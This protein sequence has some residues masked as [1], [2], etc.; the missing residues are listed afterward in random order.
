MHIVF[1]ALLGLL[2]GCASDPAARQRVVESVQ[3]QCLADAKNYVETGAAR[4]YFTQCVDS[5]LLALGEDPIYD[6]A[7][8]ERWPEF[9]NRTTGQILQER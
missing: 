4:D 6:L 9:E 8:E 7:F 3:K 2:G 1:L 5:R